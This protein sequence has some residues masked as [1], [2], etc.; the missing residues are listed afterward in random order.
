MLGKQAP[1]SFFDSIMKKLG[2]TITPEKQKFFKAW[3]RA[4]NTDAKFNPLA[5]TWKMSGAESFNSVG[6][7]NYNSEQQ[8]IDATVKTLKLSYYTELTDKLK[9]DDITARELAASTTALS[10]WSGGN[11]Q[12]VSRSLGNYGGPAQ[13]KL[14]SSSNIEVESWPGFKQWAKQSYPE[15]GDFGSRIEIYNILPGKHAILRS[16]NK[17]GVVDA[18]NFR[19]LK[20]TKTWAVQ[21]KDD[22]SISL[23][24]DGKEYSPESIEYQSALEKA[25]EEVWETIDYVQ[26]VLDFLGFIPGFGDVIDIINA[27]IYFYRGKYID[28]ALSIIAVIPVAGSFIKVGL[29]GLFKSIGSALVTKAIKRAIKGDPKLWHSYLEQ[30]VKEGKI[31]R[32][33]LKAM[34][35]FGDTAAEL[36]R[37]TPRKLKRYE[38]QL[39]AL[40]LEDFNKLTSVMDEMADYV[41]NLLRKT[42]VPKTGLA[43]VAADFSKLPK[44]AGKGALKLAK[45]PFKL[46][47]GIINF[48]LDVVT[49]SMWGRSTRFL[50]KHFGATAK[51]AEQFANALKYGYRKKLEASPTL[52][53]SMIKANKMAPGLLANRL[54]ELPTSEIIS[55]LNKLK[56]DDPK[57]YKKVARQVADQSANANNNL[58]YRKYIA[59]EL[60]Q[61]FQA[62]QY[63]KR[64]KGTV[65][66]SILKLFGQMK[67]GLKSFDVIS[68]ELQDVVEKLGFDETDDPNGVV[69]P[70]LIQAVNYISGD[71]DTT[72]DTLDPNNVISNETFETMKS[73]YDTVEGID[74]TEKLEKLYD[75]GYDELQIWAFEKMLG[76]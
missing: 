36:I 57:T 43:K 8:G 50:K 52:T 11:G 61:A 74:D 72:K 34:E 6:V 27:A 45:L 18:D 13:S 54:N 9:D 39:K 48:A 41:Q 29:K 7:Q 65:D 69:V 59:N 63:G 28:G 37:M 2:V 76:L 23:I 73:L 32:A 60:T 10:K 25:G 75:D 53:A 66:G 31:T 19:S 62:F 56:L 17:A 4:E 68:N 14:T 46:V 3:Q 1:M 26:I 49:G 70:L 55:K 12:Y 38:K 24:I 47:R 67:F 71:N 58:Y 21:V 40:G 15:I 44:L 33:N 35:E 30:A 64:F 42:P 16:D 5:T 22:S 51:T 20:T